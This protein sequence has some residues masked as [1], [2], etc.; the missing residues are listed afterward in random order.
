MKVVK[1][2]K[3]FVRKFTINRRTWLRGRP[4]KSWLRNS[5]GSM[6]CLGHFGRA[7]GIDTMPL[8]NRTSPYHMIGALNYARYELNHEQF[9]KALLTKYDTSTMNADITVNLMVTNDKKSMPPKKREEEIKKLFAEI[10]APYGPI[11]VE[12]I[13]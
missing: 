5:N 1:D 10:P 13:N 6:C 11:E 3:G 8:T 12:F 7:C 2:V 4:Y 9:V